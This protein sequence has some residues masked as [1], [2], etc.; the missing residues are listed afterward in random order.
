MEPEEVKTLDVVDMMKCIFTTIRLAGD[1]VDE[2]L[3]LAITKKI[4]G[5]KRKMLAWYYLKTI[6][7]DVVK[8]S[9]EARVSLFD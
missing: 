6:V 9:D 8:M 5:F 3:L 4:K 2:K 1:N 7:D